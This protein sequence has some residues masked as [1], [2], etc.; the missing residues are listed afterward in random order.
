LTLQ[1]VQAPVREQIWPV[2]QSAPVLQVPQAP[3]TQACPALQ[4]L[5]LVQALHT[6][7]LQA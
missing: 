2:L 1:V 7:F 4:S 3:L 5:M 6:P